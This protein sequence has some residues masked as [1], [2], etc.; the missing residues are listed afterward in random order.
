MT[1]TYRAR[2][3]ALFDEALALPAGHRPAWIERLCADEPAM[4]ADVEQ[5]LRLADERGPDALTPGALTKNLLD[6]VLAANAPDERELTPG[7]RVG[8]WRVVREIG[9]GGMGT[10]YLVERVGGDFE[11]KGALKLVRSTLA[12]GAIVRRLQRER[13]ILASLTHA[14]IARLL[15]GGQLEDGRPFLVMEY[16]DGRP[17]DRYC[18]EERLTIDERLDLF[19]RACS[20]VQHAHRKLVVHRDI[21]PSNIFV[22]GDGDVKLLDFGIARL[23]SAADAAP[24]ETV[25]QPL[26]R[27]LTPEYASPEQVRGEPVAIASDVYQLGLLLY[28]LLTG[29]RAQTVTGHSAAALEQ[30]VCATEPMRPSVCVS[31]APAETA[32]ARGVSRRALART[33][34]GDLDTMALYALR[35][36]PDRRYASVGELIADVRRYRAGLPIAAQVDSVRYRA[37]KFVARH[38]V[39]LAWGLA[40]LAVTAIGLP[41]VAAQRLRTAREAARANQIEGVLASMFGGVFNPRVSPQ[42]PR[43]VDYVDRA[44]HMVRTELSAQPATQARLLTMAGRAYNALGHYEPSIEVLEEAL[45]LRRAQ[46]EGDHIEVA[47]ALEWLGQSQ[48]YFGRYAEAQTSVGQALAIRRLRLGADDPDTIRTTLEAADLLHTRGRLA[49][50]EHMLR[51]VLATLR[52]ASLDVRAEDLGHDSLPRA[53]RDLANVLRDR[54]ALD[55]AEG[56]YRE[57]AAVFR[58]LHGEPNQQVATTEVY[59]SRLLVARGE[60]DKAEEMLARTIPT[61]RRIYNGDHALVGMAL[62]ELG[63]LR[64]E[65]GRASDADALLDEAERVLQK[66]LKAGHS[67]PRTRALQA[68]LA[69]RRGRLPEAVQLAKQTL[70]EFE[71]LDMADHP[72]AIDARV[73]LGEALLAL[74]RRADAARALA[75]ALQDAERQFVAGDARTARIRRLLAA[76]PAPVT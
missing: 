11:Q 52:S 28:E 6:A 2:V 13:R 35:K 18:D 16:V 41:A 64:I 59:F 65:Q 76:D 23:L 17:I 74:G 29:Q 69:R 24:H 45:A 66:W 50:A 60:F 43:A 21:K 19:A 1:D 32:A 63:H 5:L 44:V 42:P 40:L 67:Q 46:F 10:V 39:G 61:L 31:S 54:G 20:G 70:T 9:H 58:R 71:R 7:Q 22:T 51:D 12:S 25:T 27:M 47:N 15:D 4:A 72:A 14:N 53:L 33:L 73:T 68:E 36:E 56:L 3:D 8:A 57:A 30:S 37:R 26:M 49:E 55:E 48:H 62:R 75:Q 34:A 38:R